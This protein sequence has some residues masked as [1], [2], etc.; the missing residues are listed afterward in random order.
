[1]ENLNRLSQLRDE[2]QAM[3]LSSAQ[4]GMW[5]AQQL[6]LEANP[7]VFKITEYL[8]I[9]GKVD[10]QIL[11]DAFQHTL[12]ET[13]SFQRIFYHTQ[14]GPQQQTVEHQPYVI[15]VIDCSEAADP[16]QMAG[17]W[18]E[19]ESQRYWDF[20]H[21]RL[22]SLAVLKISDECYWYFACAHHLIIDGFGAQL[23]SARVAELYSAMVA[24]EPLPECDFTP[25]T[26][27]L[28]SEERY[29]SA[30]AYQKDRQYWLDQMQ[31]KPTPLSLS[32]KR[33]VCTDI[34]RRQSYLPE[35]THQALRALAARLHTPLPQLLI[36]LTALFLHR[37]TGEQ[38]LL[39]GCPMT[40]RSNKVARRY[41][42]MMSNV[43]PLRLAID[44][45]ATLATLV[46]QVQARVLS[47][48]RHQNYRG[49][50]LSQ[51]LGLVNSDDALVL[52]HINI[53]P[54]EYDMTFGGLPVQA[55]N[56]SLGPLDDLSINVCDRGEE[57]GLELCID[58]NAALYDDATL[59]A[60]FNRLFRFYTAATQVPLECELGDYPIMTSRDIQLWEQWNDKVEYFGPHQPAY[61][62]FEQQVELRPDA[63]ALSAE[64]GMLTYDA[65][66]RRSNQLAHYLRERGVGPEVK[67]AVCC[68]RGWD[69]LIAL[70]GVWKAGGA[71][72]PIDPA[73]P[74]ERIDYIVEDCAPKFMISDGIVSFEESQTPVEVLHMSDD[75]V[76][77]MFGSEENLTHPE[78]EPNHLAYII[79]TSGSTGK[80]KGV[81]VEHCTL[82]NL[83]HWHN[84][85]FDM[86]ASSA[87]SSVAGMGFDATVW[88][89]W[90]ALCVGGRLCAPKLAVTRDPQQLLTWWA[91][92]PVD[93]SF[94]PT[95]IAEL[96]FAQDIAPQTLKYLLVGG[97]K[98][99]RNAPEHVSYQ[100]VNNYGPTETTIVTT[101]GLMK[102]ADVLHI[103]E[104]IVN[105]RIYIL[106]ERQKRVPWGVTGEIYI[107]GAGV[108]R[109][110]I[111]L[112][113]QTESRFLA[114][115]FSE[116]PG[117]RMYRSGDLARW[118]PDGN[119]EFRGRNDSQVKIRG[120][121]IELGEIAHALQACP[122]VELGVVTV[123]KESQDQRIVAYYTVS[124]EAQQRPS[125][126]LLNEQL[127]ETLPAY[128]MPSAY[129][130]LEV[131][132]LTANGKVDY[133]ALPKP[134]EDAF[135]H[136]E[137]EAPIGDVENR[138]AIA[139]QELLGMESIG[140]QDN[141]FELGGHSLLAVQLIEKLRQQGDELAIKSLFTHPTLQ[142]LATQ[143]NSND[144]SI[145][146]E[147][148][149]LEQAH[150]MAFGHD[151]AEQGIE[152][153]AGTE[154]TQLQKDILQYQSLAEK[155]AEPMIAMHERYSQAQYWDQ[156]ITAYNETG[157]QAP[158]FYIGHEHI[159]AEW[160]A[161]LGHAIDSDVPFYSLCLTSSVLPN[162]H[163]MQKIAEYYVTAIRQRQPQG[164]YR[165]IG[166]G[167]CGMVAYEIAAQ[168][169]GVDQPVSYLGLIDCWG[170]T[171]QVQQ[172][173]LREKASTPV[174]FGIDSVT[175]K[176]WVNHEYQ[177]HRLPLAL[178][179]YASE[180]Q[181]GS[182]GWEHYFA[183]EQLKVTPS[184]VATDV[185]QGVMQYLTTN[186]M[187]ANLAEYNPVIPLQ[188]GDKKGAIAI[189]IPGAGD[190]V[191]AFVDLVEQLDSAMT[192]Y[193]LQP[194]GIW[195]D[196]PPHTSVQAAA[197]FYL[198]AILPHIEGRHVH[199][200]GH[201]FGGW[202]AIELARKLESVGIQV[203]E[204]VMADTQAPQ[205]IQREYTD[206]EVVAYLAGLMEM[207]GV[208]LSMT[209]EILETLEPNQRIEKVY[210]QLLQ[211]HILPA[212]TTKE[213]FMGIV[214]AFATNLRTGYQPSQWPGA[215][216]RLLLS[217]QTMSEQ[218]IW[219]KHLPKLEVAHSP[220]NHMQLLKKR[221]I[222][223][224][225]ELIHVG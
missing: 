53:L 52:T 67:V 218:N 61:R 2:T 41:A 48:V 4:Q 20:D 182:M 7:K 46:E 14:L 215:P 33:A 208:N 186:P 185:A 35:E 109:G 99:T 142:Q 5:F 47:T 100:L 126:K 150:L 13:E 43:L 134:S 122:D 91:E 27:I 173:Q 51:E 221:H 80:P 206:L 224:L 117:A 178:D 112:P 128:M 30:K 31:G 202:V 160:I 92:Q 19:Q 133:R 171:T 10:V 85:A 93:V 156:F 198:H 170:V 86:G 83:I 168:L 36:S 141:F 96:A 197:D 136:R 225:V 32:D 75:E 213:Q 1:M 132:P 190:N 17:E 108:T 179:L 161:Q 8:K 23:L 183:P 72:V 24:G 81:M 175:G 155:Q 70:L 44:P 139:W 143:I 119:I 113:E 199:V 78:Y 11:L 49:E 87:T 192:V 205:A 94:L 169:Q 40:G 6:N 101:S 127:T 97:D 187:V 98:L 158:L 116:L 45:S 163:T 172:T 69:W 129:V 29:R 54:F 56:V 135:I 222:R 223:Q 216:T 74:M 193:G 130:D 42:G 152:D 22:F 140:R 76:L 200:I 212:A 147:S 145:E 118:L 204:L 188:T 191:F 104:P 121:R 59:D 107:G 144:S 174:V 16:E 124:Q 151:V 57:Q 25:L 195:G 219:L 9:D 220:V 149:A 137:Y 68:D 28:D 211:H 180:P 184:T 102:G 110:Y 89:V 177:I 39:V 84:Q 64:E 164:P 58:A 120:F 63:I 148:N 73:Y 26:K 166:H 207:H 131:M 71:Y 38:D 106:D 157:T 209:W 176:E 210:Q 159:D 66:N 217:N 165:L 55:N 214:R 37:I 181:Q 201:S 82:T 88:E 62:L 203:D 115:P 77:W 189:C 196:L 3:P 90:P 162:L 21:D 146:Q 50:E 167:I 111:N 12:S 15:P 34:S 103:G 79:Y 194:R 18:V 154:M 125:P 153:S 95:P 114:D 60:H 138:L 65:L 105:S 123:D